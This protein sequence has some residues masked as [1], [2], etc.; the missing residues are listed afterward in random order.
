MAESKHDLRRAIRVT[1]DWTLST[2]KLPASLVRRVNAHMDKYVNGVRQPIRES[3][4]HVSARVLN[5]VN[6]ETLVSAAQE[7][8]DGR[9]NIDEW[10]D[11]AEFL[12]A[13]ANIEYPQDIIISLLTTFLFAHPKQLKMR[14][15][16]KLRIIWT[17]APADYDSFDAYRDGETADYQTTVFDKPRTLYAVRVSP[18]NETWQVRRYQSGNHIALTEQDMA[19]WQEYI[20][21]SRAR[22]AGE[23]KAR[24]L[25]AALVDELAQHGIKEERGKFYI[26]SDAGLLDMYDR[27]KTV[28]QEMHAA[29]KGYPDFLRQVNDLYDSMRYRWKDAERNEQIRKSKEAERAVYEKRAAARKKLQA[30]ATTIAQ[31]WMDAHGLNSFDFYAIPYQTVNIKDSRYPDVY[32]L[33]PIRKNFQVGS[34]LIAR[35]TPGYVLIGDYILPAIS[36]VPLIDKYVKPSMFVSAEAIIKDHLIFMNAPTEYEKRARNNIMRYLE[37]VELTDG[38]DGSYIEIVGDGLGYRLRTSYLGGA[39]NA[40]Y[41]NLPSSQAEHSRAAADK[42]RAPLTGSAL[43]AITRAVKKGEYVLV[44]LSVYSYNVKPPAPFPHDVMTAFAQ[45]RGVN[46]DVLLSPGD[47]LPATFGDSSDED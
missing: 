35:L 41:Y 28:R 21:E 34:V 11:I 10:Y 44:P 16:E 17:D 32:G 7:V 45:A 27:V 30:R 42:P 6:N 15:S 3:I 31:D 46:G 47:S 38:Q 5:T 37:G 20:A 33:P 29:T 13:N 9:M 8:R 25:Y 43:A 19:D 36:G 39:E 14:G 22:E 40:K 1:L 4:D 18:E 12:V 24:A 2:K 23:T 26:T